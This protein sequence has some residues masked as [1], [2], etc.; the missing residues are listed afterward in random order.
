MA[1]LAVTL[2]E[3]GTRRPIAPDTAVAAYRVVQESLTNV[4]QHA[5]AGR[6]DVRLRW[7]GDALV[8]EVRDDGRGPGGGPSAPAG[9]A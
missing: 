8:L 4:V 6:V 5:H 1:G 2:E 7:S 3:T 9:T